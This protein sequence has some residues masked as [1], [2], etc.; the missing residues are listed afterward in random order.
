MPGFLPDTNCMIAAVCAWHE[1][2]L[3]A[4][5]EMEQRLSQGETLTVAAPALVE[6]YAVLTRLPPPYRLAPTDAHT[7]LEE[8]FMRTARIIPLDKRAYLALLRRAPQD[9]IVGGRTYDAVIAACA[10]KAKSPVILTF[11]AA[12]FLSFTAWE[13]MIVVPGGDS[14]STAHNGSPRI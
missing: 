6:A 13:L 1:H 4:I 11:N 8:N 14:N 7:L 10:L 12:H 5:A 3:R 9:G 2:H